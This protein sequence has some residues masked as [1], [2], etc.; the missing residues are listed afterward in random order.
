MSRKLDPEVLAIKYVVKI[1][2]TLDPSTR[3]RVMKYL[4][5]RFGVHA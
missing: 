1:L 2:T 5:R 3:E 4:I